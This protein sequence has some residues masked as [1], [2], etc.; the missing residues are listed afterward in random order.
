MA[1]HRKDDRVDVRLPVPVAALPDRC[2]G[3]WIPATIAQAV[4]GDRYLVQVDA[5]IDIDIDI[6][7]AHDVRPRR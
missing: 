1:A 5:A 3:D 2:M 7:N 6:V 4:S